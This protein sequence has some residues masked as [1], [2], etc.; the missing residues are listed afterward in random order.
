MVKN[1]RLGS[2]S[3]AVISTDGLTDILWIA[4]SKASHSILFT[5]VSRISLNN[6]AFRMDWEPVMFFPTNSIYK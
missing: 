6:F 3:P 2:Y 5:D 4:A 1:K